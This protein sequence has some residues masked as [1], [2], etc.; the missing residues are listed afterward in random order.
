MP[1]ANLTFYSKDKTSR[2][3]AIFAVFVILAVLPPVFLIKRGE[4]FLQ[5]LNFSLIPIIAV[6]FEFGRVPAYVISFVLTLTILVSMFFSEGLKLPFMISAVFLNLAALVP[7]HFNRMYNEYFSSKSSLFE[8]SKASFDDFTN[9]LKALKELNTSLQNQ[10]HDILDLYEVTKKMGA[11][12]DMAEMLRVFRDAVNKISKFRKSSV[13]LIDDSQQRPAAFMTYEILNPPLAKPQSVDI[14]C[15][16]PGQFDKFLV[17]TVCAKKEVI[18]LKPPLEASHPFKPHLKDL[19]ES[20]MGLPLLSEGI[21]IGIWTISG[22]DEEQ[23][24][25][26]SILA[27]QLALEVK[28]INLYEKIQA[29]AITDG[30]TGIYVRRHFLER[31]NEEEARAK[32]HSLKLSI[33]MID[34]DHFKKCNDTYGHLVGDIVL[35]ETAKIMKEYVRQVDLIGRYGGEEFIIAL[36]DTDRNS[37]VNVA[38]RIRHAVEKRRFRAYDEVITSTISIGVSTYPDNGGEVSTI[39]DR[40]DQALYKAKAE[41]RNKVI[42]FT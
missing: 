27:E 20:F 2:R 18:H 39:I 19:K 36:P 3:N 33:L 12:M 25:N 15:K 30:L 1:S 40:A 42:A 34:L 24:E 7:A 16:Q 41:G 31:L 32:R 23:A 26:L 9:D 17:E 37:A 4:V 21:P 22:I 13:I 6:A 14:E 38:D 10:V 28:K 29:L 8:K 5:I 11:S 35:K